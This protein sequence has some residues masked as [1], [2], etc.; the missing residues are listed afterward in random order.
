MDYSFL[1]SLTRRK[2]EEIRE[3]EKYQEEAK[4]YYGKKN[5]NRKKRRYK[6]RV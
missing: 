2:D 4:Y 3:L 6:K 1:K 5:K